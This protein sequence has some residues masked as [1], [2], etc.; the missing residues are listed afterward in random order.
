MEIQLVKLMQ[1]STADIWRYND[2]VQQTI[3]IGI[4]SKQKQDI[5]EEDCFW[6]IVIKK[7]KRNINWNWNRIVGE[8]AAIM[9]TPDNQIITTCEAEPVGPMCADVQLDLYTMK[10]EGSAAKQFGVSHK[11]FSDHWFTPTAK[12]PATWVESVLEIAFL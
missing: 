4:S 7:L 12:N 10:I 2:W 9:M 3:Q 1:V 8:N 11:I 6:S 5:F